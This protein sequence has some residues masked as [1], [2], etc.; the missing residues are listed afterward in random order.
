MDAAE[1]TL[2]AAEAVEKAVAIMTRCQTPD[3]V[4]AGFLQITELMSEVPG[5]ATV[6]R[7]LRVA[8]QR[9]RLD[10]S[11]VLQLRHQLLQEFPNHAEF[12]RQTARKLSSTPAEKMSSPGEIGRAH[13]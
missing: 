6:V 13:V 3:E 5:L 12:L 4:R 9:G 7:N 10:D 2:K 11:Q 1:T 8:G